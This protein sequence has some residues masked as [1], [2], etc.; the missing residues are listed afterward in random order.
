MPLTKTTYKKTGIPWMPEIPRD[1]KLIK[2]KY[3]FI[4]EKELNSDLSENNR[5]SLTLKGVIK[6]KIN[7][8]E[9][10][11]PLNFATYQKFRKDDLVFKLID[12]ENINTS[13][14]GI[15]P[16]NGI[17]SSAYIRL[18][19]K[20]LSF[21]RFY[22]YLYYSWYLKNIYNGLGSGVRA[23][24]SSKDLMDLF[25]PLPPLSEQTTIAHYLD[26]KTA[27]INTFIKNKTCLIALLKEQ[28]QAVINDMV[29]GKR[30]LVDGKLQKPTQTKDSGIAWLG[31]IPR[32]W[33]VRR[34]KNV[35]DVVL[36]K[37]LCGE[38]KGGYSLKPYLKSK[39]IGRENVI[40]DNVEKMWFSDKELENY[41]IKEN[42]LLVSEGG[43]VG[44]TCIWKNEIEECYIQNSV[45][46]LT[47]FPDCLPE[48]YL[49]WM[50]ILGEI[51][52]FKSIVNQVSIAH[53]TRDKIVK[54]KCLYPP[55]KQQTAITNYLKT[56]TAQIDQS[57]AKAQ[58][59]IALIKEYKEAM[60]GEAVVGKLNINK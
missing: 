8:N 10:L 34:L 30:V 9:G 12:L 19:P 5:L 20:Q 1:W 2:G 42:D 38:D 58:K 53:L 35:C 50:G 3:A 47:L 45:H 59:E 27:K 24:M 21:P 18:I 39:N 57:I 6:R 13:R 49:F 4:N 55:K 36:G 46:K 48:Y 31:A 56:K 41:R 51:G 52:Y 60:I 22:Y 40:I 11:N 29:S 44:K 16:E 33:A 32:D 37:M 43:E 54:V 23:T 14:V 28:R 17:M 7:D 25:V 15:V 26:L